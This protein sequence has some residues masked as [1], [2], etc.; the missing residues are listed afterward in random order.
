MGGLS[1]SMDFSSEFVGDPW[2]LLFCDDSASP[3]PLGDPPVLS[4]RD[5]VLFGWLWGVS[6]ITQ[7]TCISFIYFFKQLDNIPYDHSSEGDY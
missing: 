5:S 2:V 4:L 1:V 3:L 6:D 7:N